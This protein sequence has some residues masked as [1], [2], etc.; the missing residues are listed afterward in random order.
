MWWLEAGNYVDGPPPVELT[1]LHKRLLEQKRQ[2]DLL[3]TK[4]ITAKAQHYQTAS[5]AVPGISAAAVQD[6][7][8][9]VSAV[10]GC[11]SGCDKEVDDVR[12]RKC[13]QA[14]V[15]DSK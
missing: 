8:T 13:T 14:C 4:A 10:R 6:S 2:H 3:E 7:V 5:N 9:S 12:Y 1:P 15:V 11:V